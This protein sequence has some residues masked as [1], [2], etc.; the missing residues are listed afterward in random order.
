M[1]CFCLLSTACLQP[2]SHS[3]SSGALSVWLCF[4]GLD[5]G[6]EPAL[7]VDLSLLFFKTLLKG[8]HFAV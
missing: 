2:C 6:K 3:F 4:Q 5:R 1:K 7:E 8:K